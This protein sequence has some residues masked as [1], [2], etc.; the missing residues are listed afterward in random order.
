L[1]SQA[2]RAANRTG[3]RSDRAETSEQAQVSRRLDSG[4]MDALRLLIFTALWT[5]LWVA[6]LPAGFRRFELAAGLIPFGAFGL[7]VFAGFFVDVPAD[8]PVRRAVGPLLD[9][10]NGRVGAVPYQWVLDAAVGIG[11]VWLALA[12]GIPRRSRIATA[13]I[14]PAVAILSL[15]SL[16]LTGKPLEIMLASRMPA[17]LLACVVAGLIGSVIRWTPGPIKIPLRQKAARA[18]G[19]ILPGAVA[20]GSGVLA[21][22]AAMPGRQAAV[23]SVVSLTTGLLAGLATRWVCQWE[24]ARSG[25]LFAMAIGVAA[26]AI[27]AQSCSNS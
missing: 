23:E 25:L 6:P 26:G 10:V 8:D 2:V 11:L 5:A 15:L 24:R 20:V 17:V 13:W 19:V 4:A 12:F 27:L 18:A 22:C 16:R 14:M 3:Y 1:N 21:V 7:R 9:W